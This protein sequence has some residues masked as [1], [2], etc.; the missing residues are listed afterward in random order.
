MLRSG[1]VAAALV[2]SRQ[3]QCLI[4]VLNFVLIDVGVELHALELAVWLCTVV[5]EENVVLLSFF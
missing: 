2:S 4:V 1:L 5:A 3:L